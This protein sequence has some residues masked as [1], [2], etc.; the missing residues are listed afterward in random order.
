MFSQLQVAVFYFYI[1]DTFLFNKLTGY[2]EKTG[3][4]G[5]IERNFAKLLDKQRGECYNE[6][7]HSAGRTALVY[8]EEKGFDRKIRER[9]LC[10]REP[11]AGVS[12]QQAFRITGP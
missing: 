8:H 11:A 12:R 4:F 2:K 5:E 6:N 9:R 7:N 10:F 1:L 3:G